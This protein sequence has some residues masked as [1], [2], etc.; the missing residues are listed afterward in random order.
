MRPSQLRYT[1]RWMIFPASIIGL[2]V[3]AI[4]WV[5]TAR[6]AIY[7][8]MAGGPR[9]AHWTYYDMW[10]GSGRMV[11]RNHITGKTTRITVTRPATTAGLCR[12]WWPAAARGF[13]TLLAL[14]IALTRT[15]QWFIAEL[16]LPQMTTRRWMIA[17]AVLGT[18]GGLIMSTIRSSGVHPRLIQWTQILIIL[19]GLH[20]VAF[21]PVGVAVLYRYVRH[22]QPRDDP[23]T[24]MGSSIVQCKEG[25]SSRYSQA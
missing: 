21:L 9:T 18:E 2:Y 23:E 19:V 10:D 13:L 25:G 12:V 14:A 15:G 1:V 7:V 20:A 22:R 17:V 8:G 24:V 5:V 11:V 4:N 3:A 16:P 6:S